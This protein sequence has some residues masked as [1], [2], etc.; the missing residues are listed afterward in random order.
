MEKSGSTSTKSRD[1]I[2][3]AYKSP[4][5]WYDIRGLFILTFAY[6]ST[7]NFQLKFFGPNFGAEH[8]EVA[9]GT[10]TMLEMILKW[11]KRRKLSETHVIGVDY[12]D[13]MLEGARYIFRNAA[14][15]ELQHADAAELPFEDNHFDTANIANAVHCFPDVD[16][17][18]VD[19]LRVLK[20]GGILAVNV[21]LY[22]RTIWP[23][24]IF[25]TRLNNWGIKKGI[26]YTPYE[27]SEIR[28]KFSNAG[29]E[30]TS[31]SVSGNC[32][33]LLAKK[34]E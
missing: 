8:L 32:Y 18:L 25:A 29:F 34:S 16:G 14:S 7:V 1:E 21:L 23:L 6:N 27:Q 13:S 24:C 26:L 2:A 5:L 17:A 15:V 28:E 3:E 30:I 33:N 31:E 19:I 12:A 10:G 20:P 11:R 22:P 4:P 9:C